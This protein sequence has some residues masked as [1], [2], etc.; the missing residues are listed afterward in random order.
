MHLAQRMWSTSIRCSTNGLEPY[1]WG[2]LSL[3]WGITFRVLYHWSGENGLPSGWQMNISQSELS[4][5]CR[6]GNSWTIQ[7]KEL[8]RMLGVVPHRLQAICFDITKFSSWDSSTHFLNW[9]VLHC[10][11]S[12]ISWVFPCTFGLISQ[13]NNIY[14]KIGV[15]VKVIWI[16]E[17]QNYT[18]YFRCY[19]G[20][21]MCHYVCTIIDE[22]RVLCFGCAHGFIGILQAFCTQRDSVMK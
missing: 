16:Q 5:R 11:C 12:G 13:L 19:S 6:Q 22:D 21:P 18:P 14:P 10:N 4:T 15:L 9:K 7:I 2:F 8:R 20:F 17:T 3:W 1:S